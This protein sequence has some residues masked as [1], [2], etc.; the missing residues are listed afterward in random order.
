MLQVPGARPPGPLDR[1]KRP[2]VVLFLAL[3][4]VGAARWLGGTGASQ[5]IALPTIAP[6]ARP[7]R[8]LKVHVT[9]AVARP[10]LY[11]FADGLRI[12]DAIDQA[13]G[14]VEGADVG[15][16]NLA[17]RLQDG[18]QVVVPRLGEPAA[19]PT[20]TPRL[21]ARAPASAATAPASAA[22]ASAN[23]S[24]AT[25]PA[26]ASPTR[27]PAAARAPAPSPDR[28]LNLNRATTAELE[29]LPAIGRAT[30][31]RIVRH[32]DERGPFG[33]PDDLRAAGLVSAATLDR[34]RDL[35]E[36]P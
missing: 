13:G 30:A 4:T 34:I 9:G 15:R 3:A 8:E 11:T 20:A 16:L 27:R 36:A 31:D 21:A 29:A 1:W 22:T 35:V 14:P 18:Q 17:L 28:R 32:R 19:R 26:S 24:S 23:L 33:S 2:G 7:A 6:D 25:V 12:A 5:P 10:G